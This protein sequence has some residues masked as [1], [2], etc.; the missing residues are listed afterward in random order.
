[1]TTIICSSPS[2]ARFLVR[3]LRR[4]QDLGKALWG[5]IFLAGSVVVRVRGVHA[6]IREV[7]TSEG[8]HGVRVV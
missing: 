1:M 8:I 2:V 6:A 3:K 5:V 7:L 4:A